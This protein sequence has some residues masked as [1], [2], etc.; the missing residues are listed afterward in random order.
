MASEHTVE[1]SDLQHLHS[2]ELEARRALHEAELERQRQQAEVQATELQRAN[3]R[4]N[5]ELSTQ[6]L[7]MAELFREK[8]AVVSRV[9]AA[10]AEN[11]ELRYS[12]AAVERARTARIVRGAR[13]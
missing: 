8:Q 10:E 5:T 2:K 6:K 1:V 7:L 9:E 3:A 13:A 4:L 12:S 11:R